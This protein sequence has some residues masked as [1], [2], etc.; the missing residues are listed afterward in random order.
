MADKVP[1]KKPPSRNQSLNRE[2]WILA[3]WDILGNGSLEEVKVKR[4]ASKLGVTR[5]SFYWHFKNRQ[6]LI[7]A[8]VDRWFA[9][10]G[11]REA[12]MRDIEGVSDPE[13]KLWMVMQNVIIRINAGQTIALRLHTHKD[14]K[15]RQ[16]IKT[17]DDRRDHHFAEL[18]QELG[19]SS[20]RAKEL[21][22]L[23]RA[24]VMS[25]YLRNGALPREER[26]VEAKKMHDT[27]VQI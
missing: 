13:K 18:F 14:S 12:T 7:E 6:E 23:Y 2:D 19:F 8:L 9:V 10:L 5:G 22:S 15:L 4:L 26:I 1:L 21:G 25:E 3:A 11:V 16:R 24:V 27:L 17:E 20:V